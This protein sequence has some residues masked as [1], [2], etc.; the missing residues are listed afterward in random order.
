[1]ARNL[2]IEKNVTCPCCRAPV[3]AAYPSPK[4]YAAASRD[5]DGRV[6]AYSWA[7]GLKTDVVPHYYV[8]AQCTSCLYADFR[9]GFENPK[10]LAKEK[11][12][13]E[14]FKGAPFDKRMVLRKLRRAVPKEE[15]DYDGAVSLH[16]AALYVA[17][18]PGKKEAI[19][20]LKLGRLLLRLSW[21]YRERNEASSGAEAGDTEVSAGAAKIF[22]E[23]GKMQAAGQAL[24]DAMGLVQLTAEERSRELKLDPKQNPYASALAGMGKG[25]ALLHQEMAKFRQAGTL[26]K[27]GRLTA[28]T[29]AAAAGGSGNSLEEI[30]P[31]LAGQ[32]P[33][34]PRNES[35]CIKLAVD[36]FDYSA[37]NEDTDQNIQQAMGMVNLIIKLLLKINELERALDYITQIFKSGYRDKQEL[38]NRIN[39]GKRDGTMNEAAVR[40]ANRQLGSVTATLQNAAENRRKILGLIFERDKET[41]EPL[42]KKYAEAPPEQQKHALKNA[43]LSDDMIHWLQE[44]NLIKKEDDK[45]KKWFG[46]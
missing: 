3:S 20:H 37:R 7:Q 17:L 19:D 11:A 8:V 24:S 2:F 21:L 42:L 1:M 44:H 45:K 5:D 25:M 30:L 16:L 29:A 12:L 35:N 39:Q 22:E 33:D 27:Q 14:T 38:Q 41:I 13:F 31:S 18:L 36:A 15:I 28:E 4:L 9:E 23:L 34:L 10:N 26:D 43:G 32:W 40:T 6:S 46:R